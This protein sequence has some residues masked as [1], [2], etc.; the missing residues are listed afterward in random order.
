MDYTVR[1]SSVW[2]NDESTKLLYEKDCAVRFGVV[3]EEVFIED[4]GET[5]YMVEVWD[6][7][8]TIPVACMRTSRF[9]GVYN[10]E[11]YT[12]RDFKPG[13]SPASSAHAVQ[14]GDHV[15]VAYA[16]GDSR[17]G[18]IIGYLNHSG[19]KEAIN[20][21]DNPE[22]NEISEFANKE[23]TAKTVYVSEFNGLETAINSLGEYRVT[24]KGL[25]TNLADLNVAP[26]G[27]PI[28]A[29]EYDTEVGSSYY[30]WDKTG[31]YFITDNTE[32]DPQSIKVDKP[33]GQIIITS[34]KT[35]LVI[36]KA[37][38]SYA[39]T[40][41]KTT[42]D[43]TDEWNLNTK[44]TTVKSTDLIDMEAT[45]IKTKGE[46][47]QKGNMEITGN[48]KQT[49][50]TD[51]TGTFKTSGKTDLAGGANPLIYDILLTIGTGNL[52]APVV[53]SHVLLKTS[54]TKA[55]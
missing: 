11:E 33:N 47:Q 2:E 32:E 44:K 16:N 9:G 22:P 48:I 35:T 18:F 53:S 46:W 24:F 55:T 45:D 30:E 23:G 31:S 54:L 49:G 50:N 39:I 6:N 41:K 7:G 4:F 37:E 29:P 25:Q 19:R 52:G 17:E 43:S 36:D 21:E 3:R 15:I 42:F 40:N 38:E 34:G 1:D 12:V 13:N 51:I 27:E 10:Y 26:N 8:N 20:H 28:K 14:P 5:R